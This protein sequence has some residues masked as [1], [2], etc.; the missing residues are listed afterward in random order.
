MLI[1]FETVITMF[2]VNTIP[3]LLQEG[4]KSTLPFDVTASVFQCKYFFTLMGFGRSF[5]SHLY[6]FLYT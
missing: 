1:N 6:K 2:F 3:P 4:A 5:L